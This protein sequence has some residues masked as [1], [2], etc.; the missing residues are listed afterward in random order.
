M[1]S[2]LQKDQRF[3]GLIPCGI[4]MYF[5]HVCGETQISS[6]DSGFLSQSKTFSIKSTV[7]SNVTICVS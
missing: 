4:C 6:G 3:A 1:V 7:D 5:L 2:L